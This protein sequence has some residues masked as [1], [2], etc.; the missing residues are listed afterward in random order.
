LESLL[1]RGQTATYL[2]RQ[3]DRRNLQPSWL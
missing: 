3:D 1:T 2:S